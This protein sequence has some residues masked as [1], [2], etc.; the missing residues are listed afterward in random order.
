MM[1]FRNI[2][3]APLNT[4][5]GPPPGKTPVIYKKDSFRKK[6][7]DSQYVYV[8][9]PRRKPHPITHSVPLPHLETV[10]YTDRCQLSRSDVIEDFILHLQELNG[11]ITHAHMRTFLSHNAPE[12]EYGF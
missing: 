3:F 7:K 1:I 12:K 11:T 6:S 4:N 10:A 8:L 5:A 2:S 9:S